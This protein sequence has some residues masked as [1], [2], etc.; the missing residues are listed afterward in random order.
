MADEQPRDP[1]VDLG[2][3]AQRRELERAPLGV[4]GAVALGGA[5]GA[6]A[7]HGLTLLLPSPPGGI[8]RGVLLANAAGCLLIGV[9]MAV[10]AARPALPALTRPFLGVGFLGGFTTFSAYALNV[11]Q[12]ADAAT[13]L[14]VLL[15][16]PLTAL[17][18]VRLGHTAARRLLRRAGG[19]R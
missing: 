1:D 18:A 15:G 7:R 2:V 16:T 12:A 9:L 11:H 4:L 19:A 6:L 17:P 14:A 13:A 5:A 3:P 10:L 8:V